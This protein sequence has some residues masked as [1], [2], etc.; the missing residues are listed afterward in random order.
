M[1]NLPGTPEVPKGS[2]ETAPA[3][4]APADPAT[5]KPNQATLDDAKKAFHELTQ[6]PS[7]EDQNLPW[8][9]RVWNKLTHFETI[10]NFFSRAWDGMSE[11]FDKIFSWPPSFS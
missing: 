4:A 8:Y 11:A 9:K 2:A 7:S 6:K 3:P 10:T 1:P 5:P